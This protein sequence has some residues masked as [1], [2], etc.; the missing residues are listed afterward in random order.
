MLAVRVAERRH[1]GGLEPLVIAVSGDE[2]LVLIG[3]VE[4][5]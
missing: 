3:L 5:F 2:D 4:L 1:L